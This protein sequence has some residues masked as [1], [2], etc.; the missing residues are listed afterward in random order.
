MAKG[1]PWKEGNGWL[2]PTTRQTKGG[3]VSYA[4][5]PTAASVNR[6]AIVASVSIPRAHDSRAS[7]L[8]QKSALA[9]QK[10]VGYF[11][12]IVLFFKTPD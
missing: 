9:V 11:R 3:E 1:S 12:K 8:Y 2:A 5:K 7:P 6:Q 10:I 4:I